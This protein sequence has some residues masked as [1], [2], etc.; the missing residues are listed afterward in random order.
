MTLAVIGVILA[1][2]GIGLYL[3]KKEKHQ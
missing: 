2:G 3:T 1:L